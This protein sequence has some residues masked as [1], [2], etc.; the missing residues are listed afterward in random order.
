[1]PNIYQFAFTPC[2]KDSKKEKDKLLIRV[3]EPIEQAANPD[4]VIMA[5]DSR[6]G[7]TNVFADGQKFAEIF[8]V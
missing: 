5:Y 8:G 1:M 7:A 3:G 2:Q 6:A 4:L